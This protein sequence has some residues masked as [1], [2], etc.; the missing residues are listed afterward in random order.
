MKR[1]FKIDEAVVKRDN[2]AEIGVLKWDAVWKTKRF[3]VVDR[4]DMSFD[5]HDL[6]QLSKLVRRWKS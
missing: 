4:K 2:G 5:A 6:K 1:R 3:H